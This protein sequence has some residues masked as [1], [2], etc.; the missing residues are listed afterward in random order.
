MRDD[1]PAQIVHLFD[2][3]KMCT[4]VRFKHIIIK[5][6]ASVETLEMFVNKFKLFQTW[7]RSWCHGPRV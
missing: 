7:N 2:R 3:R 1:I 4:L 5:T 6:F